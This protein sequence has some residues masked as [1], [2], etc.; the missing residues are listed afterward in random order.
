MTNKNVRSLHEV[1]R[2]T[3][4]HPRHNILISA[5]FGNNLVPEVTCCSFTELICNLLAN[6]IFLNT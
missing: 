2:Y 1:A 6:V 5:V 3:M 4:V